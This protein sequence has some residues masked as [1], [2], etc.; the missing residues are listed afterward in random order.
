MSGPRLGA[1]QPYERVPVPSWRCSDLL[2]QLR[3]GFFS[4][5]GGV[6]GGCYASL[7][8]GLGTR[9]DPVSVQENRRRVAEQIGVDEC[10]LRTPYQEHGRRVSI[11]DGS[12]ASSWRAPCDGLA[13]RHQG[14]VLGIVTADCAPILFADRGNGVIGAAHAGWRGALAGIVDTTLEAMASLGASGPVEA[15]IGPCI[16]RDSYQVGPELRDEFLT[17]SRDNA[18]FFRISAGDRFLFDLSSYVGSCLRRRGVIFDMIMVDTYRDASFFSY[19]RSCHE[20]AGDYG[21]ML[22]VITLAA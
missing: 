16:G 12:E 9:D 15:V 2:S 13:T 7:N 6:S 5:L 22:S 1:D 11:L 20:R 17:Q 3:H 10:A 19:R 14:I 8:C 21:R 18:R 4:R